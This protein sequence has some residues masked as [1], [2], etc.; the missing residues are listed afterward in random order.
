MAKNQQLVIP[1]E[2]IQVIIKGLAKNDSLADTIA[3]RLQ[4]S[5]LPRVQGSDIQPILGN[6]PTV[7]HTVTTDSQ[8]DQPGSSTTPVTT[9]AT[10]PSS[11]S[12]YKGN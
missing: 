5:L 9:Q 8:L 4:T 1:Q 10:M 6:Q 11:S 12:E 7:S 2:A 3:S